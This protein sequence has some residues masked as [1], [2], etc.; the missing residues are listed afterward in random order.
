MVKQNSDFFRGFNPESKRSKEKNN[1]INKVI[2]ANILAE[3]Q[4]EANKL[5]TNSKK[6]KNIKVYKNYKN[7]L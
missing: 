3:K 4:E 5:K 7:H 1:L 6:M 2:N